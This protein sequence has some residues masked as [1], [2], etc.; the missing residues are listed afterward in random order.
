M[1]SAIEDRCGSCGSLLQLVPSQYEPTAP[2]YGTCFCSQR[3]A[4]E[5]RENREKVAAEF[6]EKV[7]PILVGF[8][9]GPDYYGYV[10]MR[11]SIGASGKRNILVRVVD[12][13]LYPP[14]WKQFM[15]WNY[16]LHHIAPHFIVEDD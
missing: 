8:I 11:I 3:R 1:Q 10:H 9:Y 13:S 16:G 4:A 14:E 15:R 6:R 12:E 5:F 7:A 2:S